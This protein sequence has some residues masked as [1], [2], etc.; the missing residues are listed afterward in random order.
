[1]DES[2]PAHEDE[3]YE[4]SDDRAMA[5]DDPGDLLDN[6]SIAKKII[7][8]YVGGHE[9]NGEGDHEG[10]D[11]E[12]DD[13]GTQSYWRVKQKEG[14]KVESSQGLLIV[15]TCVAKPSVIVQRPKKKSHATR[16]IRLFF[17]KDVRIVTM[18]GSTGERAG[19]YCQPCMCVCFPV[20]AYR[21]RT[22]D[23]VYQ[24]CK[25]TKAR[26]LLYRECFGLANSSQPVSY[27][28]P[29]SLLEGHKTVGIT[30]TS[31]SNNAGPR[32]LRRRRAH[33][34]TGKDPRSESHISLFSKPI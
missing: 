7:Q 16:D 19:H 27:T 22:Y 4:P 18:K 12:D 6:D 9:D 11:D 31:I 2:N 28:L 29:F 20:C 23:L 15:W 17:T 34:K 24:K 26:C 3:D 13:E 10:S 33:Q 30:M 14:C 25:G 5:V 32:V 1:L 21:F 8:E